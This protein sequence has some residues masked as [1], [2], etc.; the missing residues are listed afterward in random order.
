MAYLLATFYV[1]PNKYIFIKYVVEINT[2]LSDTFGW[3]RIFS[4]QAVYTQSKDDRAQQGR[5]RAQDRAA[6]RSHI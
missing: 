4:Q 3:L 6:L 2:K 5:T 1:A